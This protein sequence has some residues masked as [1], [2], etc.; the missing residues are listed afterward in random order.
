MHAPAL[1][2]LAAEILTDGRASSMDTAT[3]DP[4]RFAGGMTER[5]ELL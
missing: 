4:G 5:R 2:L 1:G 3:L